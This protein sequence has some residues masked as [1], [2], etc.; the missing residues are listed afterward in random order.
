M[1]YATQTNAETLYGAEYVLIS[2]DRDKDDVADAAAITAALESASD[3][4][5]SYLAKVIPQDE[6]PLASPGEHIKTF[7]IDIA[8]YRLSP[9]SGGA[10]TKEKRVR[11]EDAIKWLEQV[12]E[13]KLSP[14]DPD[15]PVPPAGGGAKIRSLTPAFTRAN[16]AG[17]V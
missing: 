9:D 8:L 16:L 6:L 15:N 10:Y 14:N 5:D 1:A 11:Y 17:L 13:G 2:A 3:R 7:T 12:A 4:I